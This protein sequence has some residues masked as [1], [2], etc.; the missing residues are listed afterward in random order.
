VD[1]AKWLHDGNIYSDDPVDDGIDLGVMARYVTADPLS[2][3]YADA[4][5]AERQ[6]QRTEQ[7]KRDIEIKVKAKEKSVSVEQTVEDIIREKQKQ[8]EVDRRLAW[9]DAQGDD[10]YADGSI[11]RF[12]KK[13]KQNGKTYMYVAIRANNLWYAT[14]GNSLATMMNWQDFLMWLSEDDP[15]P[16]LIVQQDVATAPETAKA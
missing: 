1:V 13:W 3:S 9:I 6:R 16:T 4:V 2:V 7:L 11:V 8:K 14:S 15:E 10:T 5:N 12:E